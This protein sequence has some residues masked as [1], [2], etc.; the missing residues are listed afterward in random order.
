MI[1]MTGDLFDTEAPMIGHGVNVKGLMGA[2][3]AKEFAR[4]FPEMKENYRRR[5]EQGILLPGKVYFYKDPETGIVVANMASQDLPGP[6][7]RIEWLESTA[8]GALALADSR[9]FT[10]VALPRIG[11]GIGGL[12]WAEVKAVLERV[13]R[14]YRADF[15]VWTLP[16]Q[17]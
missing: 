16:G 1:E 5:C 17:D 6:H 2:G 8:R 11:C 7:A 3:I 12:E 13:E 10:K 4:R 14:S 15:E 9:G